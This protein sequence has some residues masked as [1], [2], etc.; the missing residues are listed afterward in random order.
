MASKRPL[1]TFSY[2]GGKVVREGRAA[3]LHGAILSNTRRLM[4]QRIA[5]VEICNEDEHTLVTIRH[6]A[7]D[8]FPAI[9]VTFE[10]RGKAMLARERRS[11]VGK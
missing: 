4:M 6:W 2:R 1:K 11:R 10:R 5:V 8:S 9:H 7:K 3:S